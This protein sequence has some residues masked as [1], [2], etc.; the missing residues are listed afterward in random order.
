MALYDMYDSATGAWLK[1][2]D[3]AGDPEGGETAPP[4]IPHKNRAFIA[5]LAPAGV[6][7]RYPQQGLGPGE[8]RLDQA[9]SR[10][11]RGASGGGGAGQRRRRGRAWPVSH[12]RSGSGDDL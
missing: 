4:D 12:R 3:Y 8:S 5:H 9:R 10:P 6:D 1:T 2:F 7:G 11:G